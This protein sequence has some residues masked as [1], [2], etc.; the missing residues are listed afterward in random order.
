MFD[1]TYIGQSR[2]VVQYYCPSLRDGTGILSRLW[3]VII[4]GDRSKPHV[5]F[6]TK[7][8]CVAW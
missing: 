6:V 1:V 7:S 2:R 8:Q 3:W 5:V 4:P